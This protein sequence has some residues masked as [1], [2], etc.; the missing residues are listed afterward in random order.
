MVE[1]QAARA[2][3]VRGLFDAKAASWSAKYAPDGRLTSRLTLLTAALSRHVPPGGCVRDLG[4]GTGELAR[5]AAGAGLRSTGCDISE[6]ML[7]HAADGDPGG[8]VR[9]M[10]LDPR[11]R[12]L[13]FVAAAFD[14]VVA[15]SLLEY[16]DDPAAVLREC[17]RVLRPGGAVLCTVPD[18]THPV[19]WLEWPACLAARSPLASAAGDRWPRMQNHLT[20]LRISRQRRRA[21]WWRSAALRSGLRPIPGPVDSGGRSTLRLLAFELTHDTGRIR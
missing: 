14:A 11:W 3:Q 15:S 18:L 8:A 7:L 17:A 4:C 16:V 5:A 12:R 19:R 10:R 6:E 13:P 9:W 20:Y 1:Q 2:D 21:R